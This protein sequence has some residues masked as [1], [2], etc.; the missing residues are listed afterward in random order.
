M[1]MGYFAFLLPYSGIFFPSTFG[2]KVLKL[3]FPFWRGKK[4][5]KTPYLRAK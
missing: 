1:L 4:E 2:K 3:L 5:R